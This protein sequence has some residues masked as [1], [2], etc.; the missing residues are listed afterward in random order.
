MAIEWDAVHCGEAAFDRVKCSLR[1]T[2]RGDERCRFWGSG[3]ADC[4]ISLS[5]RSEQVAVGDD[6]K[7]MRGR[8]FREA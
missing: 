5:R 6:G 2:T 1:E 4:S 7:V 8:C 3:F